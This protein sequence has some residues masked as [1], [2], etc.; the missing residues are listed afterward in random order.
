[1]TTYPVLARLKAQA[2]KAREALTITQVRSAVDSIAAGQSRDEVAASS[3]ISSNAVM[4][5]VASFGS[6]LG[7]TRRGKNKVATT[8]TEKIASGFERRTDENGRRRN[9]SASYWRIRGAQATNE[10]I[11][12]WLSREYPAPGVLD[13]RTVSTIAF[14]ARLKRAD[15]TSRIEDLDQLNP[16]SSDLASRL[17]M[18]VEMLEVARND[19]MLA[20][21]VL[22]DA[23]RPERHLDVSDLQVLQAAAAKASWVNPARMSELQRAFTYAETCLRKTPQRAEVLMSQVRGR[24]WN[25]AR[26]I[27]LTDGWRFETI[28]DLR[29]GH[30]RTI[31]RLAGMNVDPESRVERT[32]L[33]DDLTARGLGADLD[34][35]VPLGQRAAAAGVSDVFWRA[36]D[37]RVAG[38]A[39]WDEEL[40]S[41][42][43]DGEEFSANSPAAAEE[44][45]QLL[46][47]QAADDA[48]DNARADV[49]DTE[50]SYA[51]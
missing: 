29:D 16:A 27:Q 34:K 4:D 2:A 1:M 45:D 33:R 42:L 26:E 12:R 38:A 23:G 20:L 3:G 37:D 46:L 6:F 8:S 10:E 49:Y 19:A 50:L 36:I 44:I 28:G 22:T 51:V 43:A 48:Q 21:D 31:A 30:V 40:R 13:F 39:G 24:C 9:V 41:A 15:G 17:T 14:I 35:L 18:A 11:L 7:R 25:L 5:L 32:K 47:E